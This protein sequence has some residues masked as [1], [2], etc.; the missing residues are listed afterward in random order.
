[1]HA[2]GLY[3]VHGFSPLQGV[4]M[5]V[6]SSRVYADTKWSVRI[7]ALELLSLNEFIDFY[8][9]NGQHLWIF[10]FYS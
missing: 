3:I 2:F 7:S 10:V 4:G 8:F 6:L 1:M 5:L 9:S